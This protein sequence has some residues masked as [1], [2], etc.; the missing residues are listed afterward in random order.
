[1]AGIGNL[2]KSEGCW[3]AGIDP[4]RAVDRLTDEEAVAIIDALRPRMSESARTGNQDAHRRV[5]RQAGRPCPRCGAK[6]QARGQ[7]DDNRTTF[8]CPGCQR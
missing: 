1:M 5:H 2:W 3:Q 4:W 8:W 7:G 6:I